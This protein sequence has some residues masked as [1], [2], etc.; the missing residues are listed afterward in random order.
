MNIVRIDGE[1]LTLEEIYAVAVENVPVE[2][3]ADAFEKIQTARNYVEQLVKEDEVV[4]GVT[5]GFGK[6]SNVK[7]TSGG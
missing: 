3:N 5:T 7:I 2:L 1:H 6:F 4:Y